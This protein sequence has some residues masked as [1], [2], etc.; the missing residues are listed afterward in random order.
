MLQ[1]INS[2]PHHFWTHNSHS[3]P[4]YDVTA[5]GHCPHPPQ[6]LL[7]KQRMLHHSHRPPQCLLPGRKVGLNWSIVFWK[8]N[9]QLP[10]TFK[11]KE[12]IQALIELSWAAWPHS[13]WV[14]LMQSLCHGTLGASPL[15]AA[16][17]WLC[18]ECNR[19]AQELCSAVGPSTGHVKNFT[20]KFLV[21]D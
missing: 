11:L 6:Q 14:F 17:L 9:S 3:R 2:H 21:T 1:S 19:A 18:S 16:A 15:V 4:V 5:L 13:M 10:Y 20:S 12:R 7:A 8:G